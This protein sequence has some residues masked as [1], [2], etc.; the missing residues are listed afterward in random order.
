MSDNDL[1]LRS[2]PTVVATVWDLDIGV[3]GDDVFYRT[4]TEIGPTPWRY[5]ESDN[6]FTAL[7][8][9]VAKIRRV[10]K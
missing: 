10:D 9:Y 8:V 3:N 5:V 2:E 1:D 6:S 4:Q 7:I